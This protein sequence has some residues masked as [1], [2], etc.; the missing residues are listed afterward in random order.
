[1][2]TQSQ[3]SEV[4]TN[5]KVLPPI[6]RQEEFTRKMQALNAR[7][8]NNK[9]SVENSLKKIN[10]T[11]PPVE[12]TRNWYGTINKESIYKSFDNVI[13]LFRDF[14]MANGRAIQT[15]NEN[16][17]SILQ[18][19][20]LLSAIEVDLYQQI[21]DQTIQSN[22][23]RKIFVDWC[24]E[25][26]VRDEEVEQLFETSFKRA[27]T[28]RDRINSVRQEC[29]ARIADNKKRIDE[30]SSFKEDI[31]NKKEDALASLDFKAE[32]LQHG[33]SE[34]EKRIEVR[35][36]EIRKESEFFLED[37]L[38][39]QSKLSNEFTEYQDTM[40]KIIG[41]QDEHA[42][43]NKEALI[44]LIKNWKEASEKDLD[45]QKRTFEDTASRYRNDF[46]GQYM[47]SISCMK[48]W[49][50]WGGVSIITLCGGIS[51]LIH[52]LFI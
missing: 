9:T 20:Q 38:S 3:L 19:I 40:M 27:Y 48:K 2:N 28:L 47:K 32:Q 25:H 17:T 8:N 52:Y 6:L 21:D 42:N 46:D 45:N 31:K 36:S 35:F 14:A 22:E 49:M 33:I 41:M 30:L 11:V 51:I 24:R 4:S 7:I 50:I 13:E 29:M 26:G 15:I 34:Q 16:E 39:K 44:S 23:I 10:K 1:M 5:N 37:I 18:L 43:N 12:I